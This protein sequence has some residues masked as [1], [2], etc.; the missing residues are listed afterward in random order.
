[1][2]EKL[3]ES[4]CWF[5]KKA[6]GRRHKLFQKNYSRANKETE[7]QVKKEMVIFYILKRFLTENFFAPCTVAK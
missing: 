4:N 2:S 7:L 5:V 6:S 1:M 3:E